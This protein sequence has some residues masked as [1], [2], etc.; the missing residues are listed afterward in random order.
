MPASKSSQL[1][2]A[3]IQ[4]MPP[5]AAFMRRLG[6][7]HSRSFATTAVLSGPSRST[8]VLT[9]VSGEP[10]SHYRRPGFCVPCTGRAPADKAARYTRGVGRERR[11]EGRWR[12]ASA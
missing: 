1:G 9:G 4:D 7:V 5:L 3:G 8:L 12:R 11:E 2:L 6:F 10:P